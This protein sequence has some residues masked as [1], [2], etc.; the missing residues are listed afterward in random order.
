MKRPFEIVLDTL[1]LVAR[2]R[3]QRALGAAMEWQEVQ[4]R[5]TEIRRYYEEKK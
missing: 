5:L 2:W 4:E 3:R 1:D